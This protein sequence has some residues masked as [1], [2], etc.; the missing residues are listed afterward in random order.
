MA[1]PSA[2]TSKSSVVP[3]TSYQK[4]VV[5]ILAFLQFTVILD[6][7]ILS[8][9][10]AILM[11]AMKITPAQFGL[12]VS[13][14][15]FSAGI[16]GI[17]AAGYADRIDRK[18]F[19]LIFYSGFILG[20]LFCALAPT[21]EFLLAAR[22]IT[23]LFGGVIGSIVFAITTDL[24]PFEQR[25]RVMGFIQTAFAGS[26]VLGIPAGLFLSNHF[27]WHMPFLMIVVVSILVGFVIVAKLKPIDAH[28]QIKSEGKALLHLW[29]TVSNKKYIQ[30]F[31]TVALLSTGGF[32]LMPFGSAFSVHNLGVSLDDLPLV[33]LVTG[34]CAIVS[35]P[36]VG[37]ISDSVGKFNV[38]VA[39][40][41]LSIIMVI[42]YTN[43][44]LSPLWLVML[45]NV[46]LFIG[47]FSR[48]IPSQALMSAIPSPS[49]RGSFMAVSSSIQQ[50]AGGFASILAGLI[51]IEKSGGYLERF[52]M[53]GYCVA[54]ATI[55]TLVMM[56]R[57][58]K[59]VPEN[60][61]KEPTPQV[62][63]EIIE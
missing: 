23:G 2:S 51:V 11:P 27:G 60:K 6:F 37:K 20:T 59:Q 8:P 34:L 25:G 44:G 15:A 54:G 24:F 53:L 43:M 28:L 18:K 3:F 26:Q 50:I 29:K 62:I 16:S 49:S 32:M 46:I 30:A 58:H 38:F 48:M 47:I 12:V 31:A 41:A 63:A 17:L 45:V 33:Y 36:M 35:G 55:I 61:I 13:I 14:Y 21:Y 19:L 40:S 39:G 9:L 4:F 5:A 42:I 22:M 7:M 1:G 52:D 56:Y 10:G 57:I